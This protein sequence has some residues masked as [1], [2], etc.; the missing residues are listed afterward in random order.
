M[1]KTPA[2]SGRKRA[3][4]RL[5]R[6]IGLV[7]AHAAVWVIGCGHPPATSDAEQERNPYYQ[8]AR[9]AS[10]MRDFQAAAEFYRKALVVNPQLARA[11]LELGLLCDDKLGDPISAIYHYRQ[12]LELRP[13]SDKRQ[14]VEDF[15]E[16]ARLSLAAKLPQSPI[17]DSGELSRLQD[18]KLALLQENAMLKTRIAELEKAVATQPVRI[19][20]QQPPAVAMAGP[21]A[22]AAAPGVVASAPGPATELG[23]ARTHIVQKG[24]TL[25]SLALHYYGTRSAWD[26]I[27]QANRNLLPSKDQLKIGQQLV[28]P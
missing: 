11:H 20:Q 27:F 26:K 5:G 21:A 12:Y 17:I 7:A 4:A 1:E 9:K 16:R 13:N 8:R 2:S 19:L 23:R 10:E 6:W 18:E 24:D 28:I 25:Q 22:A 3:T 15:I 14:L